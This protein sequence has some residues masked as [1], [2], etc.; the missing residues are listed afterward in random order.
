MGKVKNYYWDEIMSDDQ[1]SFNFEPPEPTFTKGK[2]VVKLFPDH[3]TANGQRFQRPKGLND[4]A[5]LEACQGNNVCVHCCQNSNVNFAQGL[6]KATL[7]GLYSLYKLQL[8][9]GD[10]K[11]W[12]DTTIIVKRFSKG[13]GGNVRTVVSK[14]KYF[15]LIEKLEGRRPGDKMPT[16][17]KSGKTGFYRMTERGRAFAENRLAIQVRCAVYADTNLSCYGKE[18]LVSEHKAKDFNWKEAFYGAPGWIE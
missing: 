4:E 7:D 11:E 3:F 13:W 5:L 9:S 14:N 15:G 16:K 2:M 12:F 6:N 8:A 1:D 17:S 18:I 10:P